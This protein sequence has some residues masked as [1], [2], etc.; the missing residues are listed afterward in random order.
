MK[1]LGTASLALLAAAAGYAGARSVEVAPA[2]PATDSEERVPLKEAKLNIE[3]NATDRDTGFQG[4]IDSEGWRN[5]DVRGP[6]GRVLSFRGRGALGRLRSASK[7]DASRDVRRRALSLV[8]Q[9]S[10]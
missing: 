7:H 5:L 6:R 1:L 4:A 2:R 3:H 8:R 9:L 10:R